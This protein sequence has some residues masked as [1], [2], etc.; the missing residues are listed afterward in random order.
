LLVGV[1]GPGGLRYLG[2]VGTG[3]SDR[4]LDALAEMLEPLETEDSPFVEELPAADRNDAVWVSPTLVGEVRF[5]E[6]TDSMH[7]RHPSWRGLREDKQPADVVLEIDPK[8]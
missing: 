8:A 7:L 5:F 6:W 3:F 4:G 1:P 2:R